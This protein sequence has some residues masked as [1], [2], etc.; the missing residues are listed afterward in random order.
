MNNDGLFRQAGNFTGISGV[1]SG[2]VSEFW[3]YVKSVAD[4]V[5]A[6]GL[7]N[8]DF[9]DIKTV[10][11]DKEMVYIGV[12]TSACEDEDRCIKAARKAADNPLTEMVLE[13]AGCILV[14]ISGDDVGL[15]ESSEAAYFVEAIT[16]EDSN[17]I[18]GVTD[19]DTGFVS[20]AII[21]SR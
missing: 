4:A 11:K 2:M 7:I 19:S 15:Q 20:V 5:N 8:L 6:F 14:C 9:A 13:T 16:K 21:A 1:F 12:G 18:F 10:F 17:I 3:K